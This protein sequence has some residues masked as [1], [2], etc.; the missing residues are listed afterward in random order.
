[1]LLGPN[2]GLGE[3]DSLRDNGGK[4]SPREGERMISPFLS[5]QKGEE[6]AV[7]WQERVLKK[8]KKPNHKMKKKGPLPASN[9]RKR[10]YRLI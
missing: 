4:G 10:G 5:S 6:R 3:W 8:K 2:A 1:M 7:N 9:R